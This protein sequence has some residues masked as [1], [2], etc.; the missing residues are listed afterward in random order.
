MIAGCSPRPRH[1]EA[2]ATADLLGRH[3]HPRH[4][5]FSHRRSLISASCASSGCGRWPIAGRCLPARSAACSNGASRSL[6]VVEPAHRSSSSS[7]AVV[8]TFF[9]IE[10]A[11]IEGYVDALYF[12]RDVPSR[13]LALATLRYRHRRQ[14]DL[15]R[16]HDCR[17]LALRQACAGGV[18]AGEGLLRVPDCGL[19]RHEPD[20]VHCKACGTL[21][22]IPDEGVGV[23][24]R[25]FSGSARA[26]QIEEISG[27]DEA[28]ARPPYGSR[29]VRC[30]EGSR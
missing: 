24:V 14:T 3:L 21:L 16:R 2:A 6:P 27:K 28:G 4:A 7:P 18:S 20:A 12:T 30:R 26:A 8:T 1:A 17:H 9:F 11:G 5:G 29:S 10:G 23:Q 15:D 13:R 22:K 25:R 19:R